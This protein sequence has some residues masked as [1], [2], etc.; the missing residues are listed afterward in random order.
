MV[1]ENM[2]CTNCHVAAAFFDGLP[3]QKIEE[4]YMKDIS[5]SYR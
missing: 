5:I 1:F 2:E 4:I 3:E